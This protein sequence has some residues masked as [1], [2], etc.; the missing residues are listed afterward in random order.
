MFM[1]Q[2]HAQSNADL[3]DLQADLSYWRSLWT[4]RLE[5][6]N[7]NPCGHPPT[8]P[9]SLGRA[10]PYSHCFQGFAPRA[11]SST[12]EAC[13]SSWN[14]TRRWRLPSPCCLSASRHGACGAAVR[15]APASDTHSSAL[16]VLGLLWTAHLGG[17]VVYEFGGG[18]PTTVLEGALQERSMSHSHDEAEKQSHDEGATSADQERMHGAADHEHE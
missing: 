16:G 7:E 14:A 13:T 10:A 6:P 3:N 2:T 5:S 18:V 17:T 11:R 1:P 12:A 15:L 4:S 9:W 8:G